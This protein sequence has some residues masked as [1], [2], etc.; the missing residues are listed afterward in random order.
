MTRRNRQRTRQQVQQRQQWQRLNPVQTE[1]WPEQERRLACL[2]RE[3]RGYVKRREPFYLCELG[4]SD[5]RKGPAAGQ[6]NREHPPVM[7]SR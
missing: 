3:M 4:L 6:E 7:R 2:E 5:V 1:D